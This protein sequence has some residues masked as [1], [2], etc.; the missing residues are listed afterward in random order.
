MAMSI[1]WGRTMQK[2]E[3]GHIWSE[4][5]HVAPILETKAELEAVNTTGFD[6]RHLPTTVQFDFWRGAAT[7]WAEIERP[8]AYEAP[9]HASVRNY[10]TSSVAFVRHEVSHASS[11]LRTQNIADHT[12]VDAVTI[13]LRLRGRERY[14]EFDTNRLFNPGDI[15]IFEL[16]K[17]VVSHNDSLENIAL[18]LDKKALADFVPVLNQSHG[19]TLPETAMTG[20]LKSH[21]QS[22]MVALATMTQ[23][24]AEMVAGVT[25]ETL[26]AV[27][28]SA[29]IP[30]IMESEC[31]DHP[32]MQ[33]VLYYVDQHLHRSDLTPGLVAKAVGMSRSK[34]F[35]V[36]KNYGTP[37][38]LVRS[39]RMRRALELLRMDSEITISNVSYHVGY[40][41]RETF[42]R[43][44]KANFGYTAKDFQKMQ[45]KNKSRNG[46]QSSLL[47][48][49]RQQTSENS[50]A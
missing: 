6:S 29:A 19:V 14:H 43:H 20:L 33:A 21:M 50:F 42:A 22:T 27:F 2:T 40:E 38:E 37:M 15:R 17:P 45:P 47:S 46:A 36:C 5:E 8:D 23:V 24:E 35:R 7:N 34:L 32:A 10:F 11:M 26:K 49:Y 18:V 12:D 9:F 28:M 48:S 16:S 39:R 44:F 31:M 41:N 4:P 30:G 25:L 1:V 3:K 13:Q